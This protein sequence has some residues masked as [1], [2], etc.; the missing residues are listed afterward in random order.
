VRLGIGVQVVG[1]HGIAL[2]VELPA[3]EVVQVG[4]VGSALLDDAFELLA[5][6]GQRE[7]ARGGF[8]G[9][10]EAELVAVQEGHGGSG[11]LLVD[12]AVDGGDD[13]QRCR[14]MALAD[15]VEE[16]VHRRA[17][18]AQ[19]HQVG[20]DDVD[21]QLEADDVRG[22]VPHCP[23]GEGIQQ[24][25]AAEAQVDQ[26]GT[27]FRC[28]EG[29]PRAT[30][31]G[32]VGT[33]ADGAAVVQPDRAVRDHR[34][35]RGIG[36][37]RHQL[38]DLVVRQPD[39]HLLRPGGQGEPDRADRARDQLRLPGGHGDPQLVAVRHAL[40]VPELAVDHQ[41]VQAVRPRRSVDVKVLG[42]QGV[43]L[44]GGGRG[45]E[46][47]PNT[48]RLRL[49]HGKLRVRNLH[50]RLGRQPVRAHALLGRLQ[51]Q[52]TAQQLEGDRRGDP[53]GH[54]PTLAQIGR[55]DVHNRL[56]R[57][58]NAERAMVA[59][60]LWPERAPFA[61]ASTFLSVAVTPPADAER[62]L[63]DVNPPLNGGKE[64]LGSCRARNAND[65]R[66]GGE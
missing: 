1:Q 35:D 36:A 6:D 47:Q 37:Q 58:A 63:A 21:A 66:D 5:D 2:V 50:P 22:G 53:V 19:P 57:A 28:G 34:L 42:A 56:G 23:G 11:G 15:G 51:L 9:G 12:G 41:V 59:F 20:V 49:G 29:G 18:G 44:H 3:V 16:A 17:E 54:D 38:G 43:Q 26:L 33:V 14:R 64:P 60:R 55:K 39:H 31:A 27:G 32:G 10:A 45:A 61:V 46:H 13:Q 48:S 24:G 4:V 52:R 8:A 40:L 62:P 30:G 65:Q 25:S 7:L